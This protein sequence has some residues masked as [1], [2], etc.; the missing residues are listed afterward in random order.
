MAEKPLSTINVN[1]SRRANFYPQGQ[2]RAARILR[3]LTLWLLASCS[4]EGTLAV[5]EPCWDL[6]QVS[7]SCTLQDSPEP[8]Y[9]NN[10]ASTPAMERC[11]QPHIS[12]EATPDE[13]LPF[14]ARGG[15]SV[16]FYYQQGQWR[17]KVS[18]RIGPFS[19]QTVLP[20]VCSQGENVASSLEVLSRYPSWQRQ[21]QIHV[22]DRN[23]CP[24]LG[25]VVYVGELGLKG[26]GPIPSFCDSIG[27]SS[28]VLSSLQVELKNSDYDIF[29][30]TVDPNSCMRPHTFPS[31]IGADG[32]ES[33][34]SPTSPCAQWQ[35]NHYYR[36]LD[37][38][39]PTTRVA[40]IR[41]GYF[42]H[43]FIVGVAA[44]SADASRSH[45]ASSA[46][47]S[48]LS[49]DLGNQ[50]I[51]QLYQHD[52]NWRTYCQKYNIHGWLRASKRKQLSIH[53]LRIYRII[54]H[55]CRDCCLPCVI[56]TPKYAVNKPAAADPPA[57]WRAVTYE[58]KLALQ[59]VDGGAFWFP[60]GNKGR[61]VW[62]MFD[63]NAPK[64]R[65]K[66][67]RKELSRN[68]TMIGP[69][70]IPRWS[71]LFRDCPFSHP[72]CV[73]DDDDDA[74]ENTPNVDLNLDSGEAVRFY[75][76]N[77]K[78]WAAYIFEHDIF[79]EARASFL[80]C[81]SAKKLNDQVANGEGT[82]RW[83]YHSCRVC[84]SNCVIVNI[85][86]E[87]LSKVC[88][89]SKK[90]QQEARHRREE[91]RRLEEQRKQEAV[92]KALVQEV[93][94]Q[95]AAEASTHTRQCLIQ[96][97]EE[98]LQQ[99]R[100][101]QALKHLREQDT[102]QQALTPE[103]MVTSS[104]DVGLTDHQAHPTAA[105]DQDTPQPLA[106]AHQGQAP[107]VPW[108]E[109]APLV[110]AGLSQIAVGCWLYSSSFGAAATLAQPIISESVFDL[111]T[112][113]HGGSFNWSDCF[114][115]K[116]IILAILLGS[117]GV[118]Y[119][120]AQMSAAQTTTQTLESTQT[121][122]KIAA[123]ILQGVKKAVQNPGCWKTQI[124][125]QGLLVAV[126]RVGLELGKGIVKKYIN[127]LIDYKI[128]TILIPA[129]EQKILKQ[130]T[131][132]IT[133][134]FQKNNL[135]IE[136]LAQNNDWPNRLIQEAFQLLAP[137]KN[138]EWREILQAIVEGIIS[139]QGQSIA[140]LLQGTK[141]IFASQRIYTMTGNFLKNF[142]KKIT[143]QYAHHL[144][145]SQEQTQNAAQQQVASA[146]PLDEDQIE[147]HPVHMDQDYKSDLS[148][149]YYGT[150]S[151]PE[152]LA[153]VLAKQVA[154]QMT[155]QIKNTVI[156]PV[157]RIAVSTSID[158]MIYPVENAV[159]IQE[160]EYQAK[161]D[162]HQVGEQ[163]AKEKQPQSQQ[164]TDDPQDAQ[165][166]SDGPSQTDTS[167]RGG[168]AEVGAAAQRLQRPIA[169]YDEHGRLINIIGR[170]LPG[171]PIQ[172]KH[173]PTADGTKGHW[174]TYGTDTKAIH[175]GK[176]N[177]FYDAIACQ[178]PD[179]MSGAQLRGEV[180]KCIASSKYAQD[181]H[182]AVRKLEAMNPGALR[183]GGCYEG[184]EDLYQELQI[185]I[186]N[187][188][189]FLALGDYEAA[190][191]SEKRIQ[192]LEASIAW[193]KQF[194]EGIISW[195]PVV[196][197]LYNTIK[198]YQEGNT[199][200]ATLSTA[201]AVADGYTLG[202]AG[203]GYKFLS[204]ILPY[205]YAAYIGAAIAL[206]GQVQQK[207]A[208]G[209]YLGVAD[210]AVYHLPGLGSGRST[211]KALIEGN[212]LGAVLSLGSVGLDVMPF[213]RGVRVPGVALKVGE[214][215]GSKVVTEVG[216]KNIFTIAQSGGKH[217][218]FLV[219]YFG[220]T[221]AQINKAIRSYLQKI[222]VHLDKIA[223]PSKYIPNWSQLRPQHQHSLLRGWQIEITD[224]REQVEILQA[225]LKL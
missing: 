153:R 197:S 174:E 218:G 187:H 127:P 103:A 150:P 112:V 211:V 185:E 214:K 86:E 136:L 181:L 56:A 3:T 171:K 166:T 94:T 151:S 67:S 111:S 206:D 122:A 85:S 198:Q 46:S 13:P 116:T 160:E 155:C 137:K 25:E 148:A 105:Q 73:A 121:F 200:Q 29:R 216:A 139:N 163:M 172:I 2:Q 87:E 96:S 175:S 128:N 19:R 120:I 224:A 145:K 170:N 118:G 30:T 149:Y 6:S 132:Q 178:V 173:T 23:V 186:A 191:K 165:A 32:A 184:E 83:S 220:R 141:M 161:G 225:I 222:S 38:D 5:R 147:V 57:K 63:S 162:V 124:G 40:D 189:K 107:P 54:I 119:G 37:F 80:I 193:E 66:A 99:T 11:P 130:V 182:R 51:V 84:H 60:K 52:G 125:R 98:Q 71:E 12:Q 208:T 76:V 95:A 134:A 102:D 10:V 123:K 217:G 74:E 22:L 223:N 44:D 1:T 202:A 72:V 179:G 115:R 49:V 133:E 108:S 195:V 41:L 212:L 48:C 34:R 39:L 210:Q 110:Y 8:P 157:T 27:C 126:K 61:L 55:T 92:R 70:L 78:V 50:G 156:K 20:V 93:A 101:L 7:S 31:N 154:R 207:W 62:D 221:P 158:R 190:K 176:N 109:S 159:Q 196:G 201:M 142:D 89:Q 53:D 117:A 129:I 16:R 152:Q 75:P 36:P 77:G 215:V 17:A 91:Q 68:F 42:C 45:T 164:A 43:P 81:L 4:L 177:C 47:A 100:L 88:E 104:A 82:I 205:R 188:K 213:V 167:Q 146:P 113:I 97:P 9:D 114:K 144:Q 180:A 69:L 58:G 169:L 90:Q 14:Q 192:E 209:D 204:K 33:S 24:T 26:G 79:V 65:K 18:S 194:L 138:S 140:L 131:K 135:V 59:E 64:F 106:A 183:R 15:E 143:T 168:L 35:S 203:L 219:N 199:G 21:R 28:S